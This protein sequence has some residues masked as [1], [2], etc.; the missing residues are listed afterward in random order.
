MASARRLTGWRMYA[1]APARPNDWRAGAF[2]GD[3]HARRGAS[4]MACFPKRSKTRDQH[5]AA[6]GI[7]QEV[8]IGRGRAP[9]EWRSR[10]F[11]ERIPPLRGGGLPPRASQAQRG[12]TGRSARAMRSLAALRTSWWARPP[13]CAPGTPRGAFLPLG[14]RAPG[15]PPRGAAMRKKPPPTTRGHCANTNAPAQEKSSSA[16]RSFSAR[17]PFLR[18]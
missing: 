7:D 9:G 15:L 2:A 18:E 8:R 3:R 4:L 16:S 10:G 6:A 5:P 13:R 12:R 17:P 11:S 14:R 1:R